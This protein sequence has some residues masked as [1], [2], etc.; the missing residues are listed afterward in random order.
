[1]MNILKRL[2]ASMSKIESKEY[3]EAKLNERKRQKVRGRI[4]IAAFTLRAAVDPC[5]LDFCFHSF[6]AHREE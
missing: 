3:S 5:E 4:L 2:N 6:V 1:M